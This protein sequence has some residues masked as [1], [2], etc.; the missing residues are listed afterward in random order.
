M[1]KHIDKIKELLN[2]L[3]ID[4]ILIKS[5]TVKKYLDTLTGS[6]IH[7]LITKNKSYA[8]L[9]GRYL[10]EVKNKEKDFEIIENTPAKSKKSHFYIINK[11]LV[12]NNLNSLGVEAGGYSIGDYEKLKKYSFNVSYIEED[13]H[14]VRII[15]DEYEIDIIKEACEI[16]DDIFSNVL[17][18]IKVGVSEKEINAWIHYYSLMAGANKMSFDV[19][20]SSG[21]RTALPHGRPTD[22]KINSNEPIM[23]DFGI[24]YKNYQSDMTRTVFIGEPSEEMKN[25]YEVVKRAQKAGAEAIKKGALAKDIDKISRDIIVKAGYGEYYNH[26]LGHG[27]GIGDGAEYPYLNQTSDVVLKDNMIMSCEPGIYVP[28]LGGVRIEDDVV[29]RNG[30]GIPLNK[31]TKEMIILEG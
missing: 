27:I 28:N 12:Q 23:I 21:P 16:T 14:K 11:I 1:A 17:K 4:A 6:G 9:D 25:I 13:L 2:K 5:K 24:E 26:G 7:L 30:E 29:I 31:T 19:I 8:I 20:V 22:R 10:E 15:K 3:D 18:H